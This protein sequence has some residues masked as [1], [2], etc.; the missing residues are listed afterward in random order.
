MKELIYRVTDV[1]AEVAAGDMLLHVTAHGQTDTADWTGIE[2]RLSCVSQDS[3]EF[4]FAGERP[5]AARPMITEVSASIEHP[6]MP[7]VPRFITIVAG[8]NKITRPIEYGGKKRVYEV[9]EAEAALDFN[10]IEVA[11]KGFV[12]TTGWSEPELRLID[13]D[14]VEFVALP[15]GPDQI[16]HDTVT[17]IEAQATFGPYLPLMPQTM[18][19]IAETNHKA[20]D[21]K[22]RPLKQRVYAVTFVAAKNEAAN[23]LVVRAKGQTATDGWTDFEL[24][25]A[26]ESEE[27]LHF[28]FLGVPPREIAA[29]VITDTPEISFELPLEPIFPRFVEVRAATSSLTREIEYASEKQRVLTV[30]RVMTRWDGNTVHVQ[31]AGTARQFSWKFIELRPTEA[32]DAFEFELVGVPGGPPALGNVEASAEIGPLMPPYPNA[33]RIVAETNRVTCRLHAGEVPDDKALIEVTSAE[34][35]LSGTELNVHAKGKVPTSGWTDIELRFLGQFEEEVAEYAFL[36]KEPQGDGTKPVITEV[37]GFARDL[38]RPP[39]PG[40]ATVLGANG[41]ITV[42]IQATARAAKRSAARPTA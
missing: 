34:A 23:L 24:E 26:G 21:V 18:T 35:I 36:A 13:D 15:P 19:V 14:K 12:R 9:T 38:L 17:P 16:A 6:L 42:P 7:I 27:T 11:A 5:Q 22:P 30:D 2:L 1:I 32:Q 4:E 40:S 41:A 8:T 28:D 10:E 39:F 3:I 37:E 29:E 31:A 33:L 20:V 25:L